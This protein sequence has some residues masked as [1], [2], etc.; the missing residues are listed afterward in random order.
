MGASKMEDL[1]LPALFEQARKIHLTATESG[2]DQVRLTQSYSQSDCV[3]FLWG[4]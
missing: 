4:F 2:A 1:T 3:V